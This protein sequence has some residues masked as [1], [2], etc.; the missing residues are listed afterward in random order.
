MTDAS[1]SH[2]SPGPAGPD[3]LIGG[4]PGTELAANNS[5]LAFERTRMAADRTLM[6]ILRT[7]LSLIG[8]G[9]T[10]DKVFSS[11][12]AKSLLPDADMTAQRLGEALLTLGLLLLAMGIWSHA[13]FGREL[14]GRRQRLYDRGL[15][16]NP[17]NYRATPTFIV[18]ILLLLVGVGALA[19][20]MFRLSR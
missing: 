20:I 16:H 11:S 19:S 10:L 3:D 18:A 14:T 12:G 1:P 4:S 15:L 8:F 7:A 5:S 2:P 13:K 9:F 17:L 6:A